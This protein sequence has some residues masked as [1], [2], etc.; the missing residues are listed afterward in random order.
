MP[1]VMTT[2]ERIIARMVFLSISAPGVESVGGIRQERAEYQEYGIRGQANASRL[3][4]ESSLLAEGDDLGS[5]GSMV[6]TLSWIYE[7]RDIVAGDHGMLFGAPN[8]LDLSP[9]PVAL[10]GISVVANRNYYDS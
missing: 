4:V 6:G 9:N 3:G 1:T 5:L 2:T 7:E 8:F 10:Y